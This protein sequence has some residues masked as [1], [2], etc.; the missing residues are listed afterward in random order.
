MQADLQNGIC[1]TLHCVSCTVNLMCYNIELR[2][3]TLWRLWTSGKEPWKR[4]L[5][6]RSKLYTDKSL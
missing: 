1:I 5:M 3:L 6:E 4:S 2:D